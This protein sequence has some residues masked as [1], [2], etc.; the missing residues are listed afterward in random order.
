MTTDDDSKETDKQLIEKEADSHP[1]KPI[2]SKIK[3]RAQTTAVLGDSIVKN[4]YDTAITKSIK[5]KKHVVVKHF[6]GTKIEDMKHYVK[7][8]QDKLPT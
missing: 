8:T 5:H 3:T 6:S 4:V 7:L 2:I 1:L